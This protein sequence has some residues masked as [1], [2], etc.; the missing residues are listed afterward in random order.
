MLISFSNLHFFPEVSISLEKV[1]LKCVMPLQ[2]PQKVIKLKFLI[3][4]GIFEKL[5]GLSQY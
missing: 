4:R 3:K 5:F 1:L 2:L